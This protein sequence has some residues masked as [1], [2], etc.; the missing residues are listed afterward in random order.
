MSKVRINNVE[1]TIQYILKVKDKMK[2]YTFALLI[3]VNGNTYN[4]A[5]CNAEDIIN[6]IN[7]V[8]AVNIKVVDS[9]QHNVK[10]QRFVNLHP[11]FDPQTI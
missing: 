3:E 7:E 11:E 10:G 4:E 9:Y 2:F 6:S 8:N 1:I 5:L